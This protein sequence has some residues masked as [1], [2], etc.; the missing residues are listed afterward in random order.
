MYNL[1]LYTR[2]VLRI[3]SDLGFSVLRANYAALLIILA[4]VHTIRS[5]R[6]HSACKGAGQTDAKT[7]STWQGVMIS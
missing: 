2:D 5:H 7:K 4:T 1:S 3:D 6:D